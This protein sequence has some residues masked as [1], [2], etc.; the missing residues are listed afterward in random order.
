MNDKQ[1]LMK[2]EEQVARLQKQVKSLLP[3]V[4]CECGVK[5]MKVDMFGDV[6]ATFYTCFNKNCK[7]KTQ[8]DTQL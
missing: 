3:K 8:L 1:R 4:F 6:N 2:L 7:L 5:K